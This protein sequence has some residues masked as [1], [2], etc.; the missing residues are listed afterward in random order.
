MTTKTKNDESRQP[1][2]MMKDTGNRGDG[3]QADGGVIFTRADAF[4]LACP[5]DGV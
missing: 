4:G 5:W 2:M 1:E 3:L